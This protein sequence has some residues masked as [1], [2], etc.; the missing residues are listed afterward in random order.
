MALAFSSNVAPRFLPMHLP[1]VC[2]ALGGDNIGDTIEDLLAIAES[3]ARDNPFLEF[4]LDYLKHPLAALPKL[5]RF[6]E[7]HQYVTA[8]GTCRRADNG[9][10]FKGSLASQLEV[11]TKAH[12]SGCQLVDLE[13]QSALKSKP[14]AIARLRGRAGL[15]LSFHDFHSTRKLDETLEKMLKIPADFYKV[16]S[17]ATT[18]SD[19][20]AMMKFLQTYSG[21]HALIGVCMGEQ[22]IISRVLGVRAGSVFTFGAVSADLKTAPGQIS[23]RDLRSIYRI[24]QVDA[25]TRVYGVAGDPIEHSLSPVIMNTA[26][27]R[28]NVNGVYLPLHAKTLKDLLHCVREIPLHGLSVTMP[29]KQ[30]ILPHLD[31]T[32][33]HTTKVGACNTVVRGQEGK[34][35]G[36]NTDIAGV[37]RPLEQRLT[38]ENAKV[39]VLGAGGAARAAVFGL[40]ERG[41]EVWILNRTSAKAQKL[42]RQAKAHT[43]KRTDL[44]KIAFDVIIN[45]TPVGM[46]N[47]RDC[48]LKDQE[49]QARVVFD[50]VYDPVETHLLQVARGKG[51]SVIP[52]VEMFVQQ[53]ARQFEIW[54]GKPAPAGDMLRA[55]TIALQERGAAQKRST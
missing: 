45:A 27:R 30:A 35:Y 34:L 55:V 10:K 49:I 3:M 5:H 37:I 18:L 51:I 48:P 54:T 47:T 23:A 53:A 19:N 40:K 39:L 1:K 36:F 42:A 24:E 46:G 29:Y 8:I 32:D 52:G 13:L 6:L 20:V 15:I 25:A 31:N 33:A 50:M 38:I 17:T 22:G 11:L 2:L 26:L 7:T 43:I 28:E 21:Q 44:R 14:E 4:R 41:A 9:G 12:A 16:V